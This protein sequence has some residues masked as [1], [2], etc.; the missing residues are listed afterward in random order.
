MAADAGDA[1]LFLGTTLGWNVQQAGCIR[2]RNNPPQ[3]STDVSTRKGFTVRNDRSSS[4]SAVATQDRVDAANSATFIDLRVTRLI[5]SSFSDSSPLQRRNPTVRYTR[6]ELKQDKFATSAAEAVHEVVEH[7]SGIV[8]IVS[9]VVV[10]A[11]LAGG[12]FWYM[13]SR[14]EQASNALGQ[15]LV[16]Y[17]APVLPPG[18][19]KEGSM[20]TFSSE[21]ERLIAA[22]NA[23]YAVSD[24]FGA[25]RSGQYARYLA[26]LTEKDLGNFKV[27]ED[28]LRA[29]TNTRRRELASLAK[30]ALASVYRDEQRDQD[31]IALLQLL[32]DKPSVSVPKANAQFA[33]AD[34][35]ISEHQPDKAKV[36]YDQIAKDNPK[37]S[38]GQIAKSHQDE[39][40]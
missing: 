24:K 20:T 9:V 16:T 8:K 15:A 28:Q 14:E 39:L 2:A 32:I 40:K 30:Y 22:K 7:R 26:G 34:I 27:A 21:Q 29:L 19:P 23:F 3:Q 35:Y 13:T 12:I 5:T 37:T 17:N 31:A 6:H 1:Q 38:V 36:I 18:T 25:T 10:L 33:L 11:V 4:D